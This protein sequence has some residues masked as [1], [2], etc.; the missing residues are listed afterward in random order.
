VGIKDVA[1]EAGVSTTTVSHALSGKGRLPDETRARVRRIAEEMG[2]RPSPVARSLAAGRT[3]V[4]GIAFSVHP[5]VEANFFALDWYTRIVNGATDRAMQAGYALVVVPP[6]AGPQIWG[7]LPLDG[8]IVVEP[9]PD[10][11]NLVEIAAHGVCLVSIGSAPGLDAWTVDNDNASVV[12]EALEHLRVAGARSVSLASF[13]WPTAWREDAKATYRA[14]CRERGVEPSVVEL[15]ET[16]DAPTAYGRLLDD[17]GRRDAVL[18]TYERLGYELLDAAR[19]R[20]IRVPEDL[21]IVASGDEGRADSTD[22]PLTTIDF[23][24]AALGAAAA[25]TL[26]ELVEGREPAARSRLVPARLVVRGSSSAPA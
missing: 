20:G 5:E 2:Y 23:D 10:D 4:L 7:R 13:A 6:T 25:E 11:P 16:E 3:G 24:P 18:C 12:R 22:P 17:A 15:R 19:D 1:R 26:V 9:V 21:L 14:W 8:T